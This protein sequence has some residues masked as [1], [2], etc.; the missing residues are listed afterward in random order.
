MKVQNWHKES[1]GKKVVETLI[2][3]DFDAVYVSTAEEAAS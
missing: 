3:N 1:I 2:K